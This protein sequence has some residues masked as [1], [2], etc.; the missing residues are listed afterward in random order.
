MT[1]LI[2]VPVFVGRFL[3]QDQQHIATMR[4]DSNPCATWVTKR[5]MQNTF[6]PDPSPTFQRIPSEQ[7]SNLNQLCPL[8]L[9]K[10]CRRSIRRFSFKL[11]SIPFHPLGPR[12]WELQAAWNEGIATSSS[13][14]LIN[15]LASTDPS[16][17][18]E[19]RIGRKDLKRIP[20]PCRIHL[21]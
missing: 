15:L 3:S 7:I 12:A 17:G 10:G 14:T 4:N 11:V 19:G 2:L 13:D 8:D 21:Q 20:V 5:L 6:H 18:N 1:G 9:V 16:S